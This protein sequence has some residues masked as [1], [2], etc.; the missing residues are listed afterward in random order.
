MRQ[1]YSYADFKQDVLALAQQIEQDFKPQAIIAILRG[2]MTLAHF[3]GLYWNIKE[4]YAINASSYSSDRTQSTLEISNIPHLN[5]Q[6]QQ[7]LV[8]DEIVDS[9][10]SFQGVLRVLKQ[11]YPQ[12]LFKSATLFAQKSAR[13]KADFALKEAKCWI[14]FFW[15]VDLGGSYAP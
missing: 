15:E 8:V 3:L 13:F 1:Y 11:Q 7:V 6:H 14:D 12:V 4:V 9:G 2:G 5:P 10:K